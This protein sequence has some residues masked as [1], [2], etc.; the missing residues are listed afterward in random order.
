LAEVVRNEVVEFVSWFNGVRHDLVY[1][2][3]SVGWPLFRVSWR[4]CLGWVSVV[5]EDAWA[6]VSAAI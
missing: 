2:S 3:H 5:L 4:R 1:C 6:K